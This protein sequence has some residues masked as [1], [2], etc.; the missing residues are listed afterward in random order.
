MKKI[1]FYATVM[2]LMMVSLFTSGQIAYQDALQLKN[3][4]I[5]LDSGYILFPVIDQSNVKAA[6]ILKNYT[7][8]TTYGDLQK[9][10]RDNPFIR[11]PE[12]NAM[13]T[14]G[15]AGS[16]GLISSIG[17]LN[18][19]T[20]ADGI[21]RFLVERT[22]AEL[23]VYFFEQ[24]RNFLD[25]SDYGND[26]KILFPNTHS[27]MLLAGKEIY[28]Y[29]KY[30][31]AF[32]E[33]FA[34]DLSSLLG[35]SNT[36]INQ[37]PPNTALVKV[38]QKSKLYPY[39][40]LSLQLAVD[41]QQGVHPGDILKSLAR[42]SYP[43]TTWGQF[44]PVLATS[45][46]FSQSLRSAAPDRYWISE[47][48]FAAFKE[49]TFTRIYL[50][51]IYQQAKVSAIVVGGK[52]LT[53]TLTRF[54]TQIDK[55][56][57]AINNFRPILTEID[58]ILKQLKGGTE[59]GTAGNYL[60]LSNGVVKIMS[61]VN[62]GIVA[63]DQSLFLTSRVEDAE[64]LLS[65]SYNL[66]ADVR[67]KSYSAGI[68][69]FSLILQKL[70]VTPEF[71]DGIIRYGSF[72]ANV[73]TA[74][75]SEEVQQAIEVVALP[76]GSYRVKRESAVNISLNGYVG[77]YGG[78]E[79]M[80]ASENEDRFSAGLFAPVG[81]AFSKGKM[82]SSEK[83][84]GKSL[85]FFASVI[86]LGALASFRFNDDQTSVASDIKLKDIVAPG[87]FLIYGFGKSPIS[88][89]AG[90]QLGPALR[91]VDP[92]GNADINKDYYVRAAGFIVVDIPILNLYNRK[93]KKK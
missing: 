13:S 20:I 61:S 82:G 35:N 47:D 52:P 87:G 15:V 69:E 16:K 12:I 50:G 7:N 2:L 92:T 41:I 43:D 21:A 23:D 19:T 17:G 9:E 70:K 77:F 86:D 80:P 90:V 3:L 56:Q 81:F 64:F 84:G 38:I 53:E 88:I 26:L 55:A 11:L 79:H 89:G 68:M 85:S 25:R 40:N 8:K 58:R 14:R 75:T 72:M 34:H 22:K 48:E 93:D 59:E 73:A 1:V 5:N 54:A 37:T 83:K 42:R 10:F 62:A 18:V 44:G 32:R 27:I 39:L 91:D 49:N 66:V 45:N 63:S 6:E 29:Q 65:H 76:P 28:D 46:L 51:L 31:Q 4:T 30:L 57:E 24:F 67:T 33:A 78:N 60:V 71:V 36:W 74:R